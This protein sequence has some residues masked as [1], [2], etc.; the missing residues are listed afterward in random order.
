VSVEGSTLGERAMNFDDAFRMVTRFVSVKH[1]QGYLNVSQ[2]DEAVERVATVIAKHVEVGVAREADGN[3]T[4]LGSGSFATAFLM[5]DGTVGKLTLDKEDARV[6]ALLVN[7]SPD[8][9]ARVHQAATI[10][11]P[12]TMMQTFYRAPKQLPVS[13]INL[14]RVVGK[15]FSRTLPYVGAKLRGILETVQRHYD[16]NVFQPRSL[17]KKFTSAEG[18]MTM[19]EGVVRSLSYSLASGAEGIPAIPDDTL[20]SALYQ[21]GGPQD[22]AVLAEFG[23][24][25][26]K[27]IASKFL[28]DV[29]NALRALGKLKIYSVD[30]HGGNFVGTPASGL[31]MVD[32][33]VTA[34]LGVAGKPKMW[35]ANPGLVRWSREDWMRAIENDSLVAPR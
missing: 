30:A 1:T 33:G 22:R 9:V 27:Q 28:L 4:V 8:N 24:D 5:A 23:I 34:S 20:I 3:A 10:K 35:K 19:A 17:T 16:I 25:G 12:G 18:T 14:E 21:H 11:G 32:F 26:Y 13:Y 31:K 2:N 15:S 7:E 29:R 6:A